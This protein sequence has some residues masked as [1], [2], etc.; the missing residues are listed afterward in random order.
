MFKTSSLRQALLDIYGVEDKYL[1]P[2]NTDWFIPTTDPED[3]VGTWIGYRILQ[4][5]P[6][7]RAYQSG[8][9]FIRPFRIK[10]RLS[11]VGPQAEDLADATMFWEDRTDVTQVFEKYKAQMM[12]NTRTQFSYPVRNSGYNDMQA[13]IVDISAQTYMQFD[14]MQRPWIPRDPEEDE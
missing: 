3:K 8:V 6:Y 10:I 7:A 9:Y 2:L 14:T 5:A 12:Y 4:K 1:V 11:F 13:W